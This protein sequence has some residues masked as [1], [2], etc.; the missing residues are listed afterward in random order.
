[1]EIRH[2]ATGAIKLVLEVLDRRR[3]VS[4]LERVA[5]AHIADQFRVLLATSDHRRPP[6]TSSVMRVHTQR[7]GDDAAEITVIY[8][9]GD[10]VHAMGARVERRSVAVRGA[11]PGGP[12]RR[13]QRWML[14][15]VTVG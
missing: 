5:L 13:A 2:F 14:V 7:S 12:R 1:M 3:P 10:R 8:R 9:R 4:Q 11:T 15:A 6:A